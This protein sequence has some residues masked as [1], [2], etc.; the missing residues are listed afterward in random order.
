METK[1]TLGP[2]RVGG[3][4]GQKIYAPDRNRPSASRCIATLGSEP[5]QYWTEGYKS[6]IEANGC[7]ITA[8]PDLLE[9]LNGFLLN[10]RHLNDDHFTGPRDKLLALAEAAIA[11][12]TGGQP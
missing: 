8:A 10:W 6:E 9:V 2:W 12:A 3:P 7:L 4:A 11:K 5:R 1:H